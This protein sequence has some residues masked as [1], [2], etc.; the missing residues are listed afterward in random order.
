MLNNS[1]PLSRYKANSGENLKKCL[2]DPD[3]RVFV[4]S[5]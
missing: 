1:H 5:N 4:L 2:I 3:V